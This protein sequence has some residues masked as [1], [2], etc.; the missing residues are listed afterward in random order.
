MRELTLT[1][2]TSGEKICLG[3]KKRGF[4]AGLWNGFGGKLEAGEMPVA[5]AVREVQEEIGVSVDPSELTL[6]AVIDFYFT[7]GEH[8]HVHTFL[9][10]SW[11]GEITESE[12]MQPRWFLFEDVPY[13]QMWD[14]DRHWV[15][16]V[17]AGELLR[18]S[19]WFGAD[20][21]TVEKHEWQV[22]DAF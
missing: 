4:G 17:L 18:G 21:K 7:S 11:V 3:Y 16:R 13:D 19:V 2:L 9:T 12:E 20:D 10:D 15:P 6:V 8:L 1:Y 14:D 5:G 22:V